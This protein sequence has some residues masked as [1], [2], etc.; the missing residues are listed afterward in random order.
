MTKRKERPKPGVTVTLRDT[1]ERLQRETFR[2]NE[3]VGALFVL[4]WERRRRRK[5]QL[6]AL[7]TLLL[8]LVALDAAMR[9]DR[10]TEVPCSR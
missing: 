8:A 4:D 10:G 9:A 7:A 6:I 5:F 1:G 3:A 2:A